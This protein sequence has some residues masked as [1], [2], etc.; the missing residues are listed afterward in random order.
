M[1]HIQTY[2]IIFRC[3]DLE[4]FQ[5]LGEND[6]FPVSLK[7]WLAVSLHRLRVCAFC[8][9]S[10]VW[11]NLHPLSVLTYDTVSP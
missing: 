5:R 10:V 6:S 11:C 9:S 7:R 1:G 8:V 3:C 2:L 4:L